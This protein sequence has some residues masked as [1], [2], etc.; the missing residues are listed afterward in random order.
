MP[1]VMNSAD[2]ILPRRVRLAM[3]TACEWA[4][5]NFTDPLL[6]AFALSFAMSPGQWLCKTNM[7]SCHSLIKGTTYLHGSTRLE[8]WNLAGFLHLEALLAS[9]PLYLAQVD[10]TKE[11]IIFLTTSP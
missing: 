1:G 10:E 11:S 7:T 2:D 3:L 8:T 4:A 6:L 5:E 9:P